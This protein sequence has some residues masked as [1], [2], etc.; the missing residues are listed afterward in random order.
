MVKKS[1]VIQT[2]TVLVLV[3]VI[4]CFSVVYGLIG[5][6]SLLV[7]ESFQSRKIELDMISTAIAHSV[8]TASNWEVSDFENLLQVIVEDLDRQRFYV[9]LFDEELNSLSVRNSLFGNEV[10]DP[11]RHEAFNQIIR[12]KDEGSFVIHTADI[13]VAAP[14]DVHIYFKWITI[15][16]R[17]SQLRLIVIGVSEYTINP[18]INPEL[19]LSVLAIIPVMLGLV[20]Y[21]AVLTYRLERKGRE[22]HD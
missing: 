9:Q 12:E 18:E 11:R 21:N 8:N 16:Q 19:L 10:F 14:H 15:D 22:R 3:S 20:I 13:S 6:R 4:M 1:K 2:L 5:F 7:S 17:A